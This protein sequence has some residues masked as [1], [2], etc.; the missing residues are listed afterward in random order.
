MNFYVNEILQDCQQEKIYRILWIDSGNIIMYILELNNPKAFPEKKLVSEISDLIGIDDW[1]KIMDTSY[2]AIVS[3][4]YEKKHY[5]ARD[6][7]WAIIEEIMKK[8]PAIYEKSFR[9]MLVKEVQEKH[10]VT[11]P[12]VR[13]IYINIGQEVKR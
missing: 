3:D 8:E 5:E 9:M 12:T 13:K 4:E 10:Q 1:R 11:Y 6:A 7:A 2:D